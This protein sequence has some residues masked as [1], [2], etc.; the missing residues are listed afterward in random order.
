M[1]RR[2]FLKL[3]IPNAYATGI[4]QYVAVYLFL[5]GFGAA[6]MVG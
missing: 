5:T 6:W 4:L 2:D 1:N 3:S